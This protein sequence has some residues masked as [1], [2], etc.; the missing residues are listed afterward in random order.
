MK[1]WHLSLFTLAAAL[2]VARADEPKNAAPELPKAPDGWKYV[3][4]KDGTYQ[5][6]FPD[7]TKGSGTRER[8]FR[9]GGLSG[10][11][12]I[13]YCVTKDDLGLAVE[14][15]NLAGPA[16]KGLKIGDVY[17]IMIDAAKEGGNQVSEPK[18]FPVG[19]LKGRELF[20]TNDKGTRRVVLIVVK[21]RVYELSAASQDKDKTTSETADTFLKSLVITPKAPPSTDAGKESAK[22]EPPKTD[23]RPPLP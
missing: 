23:S 16:L 21:G 9:G 22:P 6:L 8:T 5:F 3:A 7:E 4:A 11:T 1:T 14:A 19:K 2:A 17:N 20:V 10:K 18:E 12:Q 13:N 15:T